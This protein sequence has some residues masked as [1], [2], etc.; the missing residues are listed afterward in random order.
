M[1]ERNLEFSPDLIPENPAGQID[2]Q[3]GSKELQDALENHTPSAEKLRE[4]MKKERKTHLSRMY[5]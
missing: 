2:P 1:L 5:A 3:F 4:I